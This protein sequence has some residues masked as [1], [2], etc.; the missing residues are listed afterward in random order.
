MAQNFDNLTI[1]SQNV[2]SNDLRQVKKKGTKGVMD[3]VT[4]SD[5]NKS[6]KNQTLSNMVVNKGRAMA[7]EKRKN[8]KPGSLSH[9]K[10]Y[11]SKT[12]KRNPPSYLKPM[13]SLKKE[14]ETKDSLGLTS[15]KMKELDSR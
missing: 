14:S 11:L 1:D 13:E 7:Q 10:N 12:M 2:T 9:Q 3:R 6:A 8:S 4:Q 5:H 15:T